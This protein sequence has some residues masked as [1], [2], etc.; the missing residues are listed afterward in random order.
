MPIERTSKGEQ[1]KQRILEAAAQMFWKGSY[2]NVRVDKIVAEAEVNKAS[3]YQYF[4]NKEQAAL[5]CVNYMF[6]QTKEYVFDGAFESTQDPVKRLEE[7][8]NRLY[9]AHKEIKD[10]GGN[11]PG[12]PFMNMGNE[13]ATD[14]ELIRQKVEYVYSEFHLYHQKIYEDAVNLGLT[15]AKWEPEVVARQL[16]G[17]LNG[18][19]TSAKLRN[20]PEDITDALPA[21]KAILGLALQ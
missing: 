19:M 8:F 6:G 20:R 1:T 15:K 12:C 11:I 9:L 3:F 16:Q 21:A 10:G 2:H 7:I 5:E 13:L 14:S 17:V 4:K 18:S